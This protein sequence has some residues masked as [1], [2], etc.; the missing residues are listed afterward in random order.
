MY[1]QRT[2]TQWYDSIIHALMAELFPVSHKLIYPVG[3]SIRR[4]C[5]FYNRRVWDEAIKVCIQL[6]ESAIYITGIILKRLI[7]FYT[8]YSIISAKIAYFRPINWYAL[9]PIKFACFKNAIQN[10]KKHIGL[11]IYI[12]YFLHNMSTSI[13]T[14]TQAKFVKSTRHYVDVILYV[15]IK[16][17]WKIHML[18]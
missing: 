10:V 18:L 13:S 15:D 3:R 9:L 11:R 6:D 8:Y 16:L 14:Y 17:C 12:L 7:S 1:N 2:I 4:Q 5:Q